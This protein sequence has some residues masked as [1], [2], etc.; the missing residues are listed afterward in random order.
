FVF[1]GGPC[2]IES[3]ESALRHATALRDITTR[4]G[5][6]FIFKASADKANRPSIT[7]YRGPGFAAGLEILAE[8]KRSVG[9]AVVTDVHEAAQVPAAAARSGEHTSEL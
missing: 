4:L 5:I 8:V 7:S 3:R 9:V 1:I 6:P 2:V